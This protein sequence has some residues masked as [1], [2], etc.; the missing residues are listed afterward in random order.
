[1]SGNSGATRLYGHRDRL[2][3]RLDHVERRL[4]D[5]GAARLGAAARDRETA[6]VP[7]AGDLALVAGLD[8]LGG[9]DVDDDLRAAAVGRRRDDRAGD[10][11]LGLRLRLRILDR[12]LL[13]HGVPLDV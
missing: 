7:E 3:R 1:M 8:A 9:A 2:L 10:L 5:L 12:V 11:G 13:H 6:L 4:R